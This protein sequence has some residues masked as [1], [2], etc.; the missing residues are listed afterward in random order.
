MYVKA[1]YELEMQERAAVL[2]AT[3][4]VMKE[5]FERLVRVCVESLCG[6]GKLL[7]FGN[8]GSAAD[9]QHLATKLTVRYKRNRSAIAATAL[10]ADTRH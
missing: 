5:P 2:A 8:G 1:H 3:G 9:A 10:T 6:G 7:F 4:G